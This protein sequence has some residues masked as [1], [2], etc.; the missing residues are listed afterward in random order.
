[1]K[2]S[3]FFSVFTLAFGF[4]TLTGC[5]DD[6]N[7]PKTREERIAEI[8]ENIRN[9][10]DWLNSV[11]AKAEANKEQ[12]DSMI[13]KDA[14]WMVDDQ[15]GLHKEPAAP[16]PAAGDKPAEAPAPSGDKPAAPAAP[17]PAGH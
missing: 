4:A 7:K 2:K 10:P 17:A 14:M 11:K 5:G 9:T 1:M 8:Q 6:P 3:I 16:A 12:L 13:L 15:D